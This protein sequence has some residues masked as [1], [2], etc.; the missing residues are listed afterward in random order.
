M[1]KD[2]SICTNCR[3]IHGGHLLSKLQVIFGI[4]LPD[5]N[6]LAGVLFSFCGSYQVPSWTHLA[7]VRAFHVAWCFA[8]LSPYLCH[9]LNSMVYKATWKFRMRFHSLHHYHIP[10][11]I[12]TSISSIKPKFTLL[13]PFCAIWRNAVRL[14]KN[15]NNNN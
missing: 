4:F 5:V 7:I 3:D 8:L 13:S 2:F 12:S 10:V 11:I 14:K 15:K 9:L 1:I 6:A